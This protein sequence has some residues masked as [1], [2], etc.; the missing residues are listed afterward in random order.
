MAA[1]MR[2]PTDTQPIKA[3]ADL[4]RHSLTYLTSMSLRCAIELGIPTM[5]QRLGDTASL[6]DLM[7]AL[8]LPPPKAP[9]LSCV[10]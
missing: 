5:I 3:Q 10:L 7:A 8:S 1:H 9:F 6:P 4:Q 2:I